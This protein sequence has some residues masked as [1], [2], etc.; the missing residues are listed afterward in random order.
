MGGPSAAIVLD[1]LIDLGLR[2]AVRIGTCAGLASG[3]ELGALLVAEGAL[4]GDGASRALGAGGRV[5]GDPGL[6][7]GLRLA[8]AGAGAGLVASTDL[9][10]GAGGRT[11]WVGGD[12]G[13]SWRSA[14]AMAVDLETATMF[15]LAAVRGVAV[16]CVLVVTD[17]LVPD[18]RI[19][20]DALAGAAERAGRLGLA[21]LGPG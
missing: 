20:D 15:T 13:A 19:A 14:G 10:R 11:R 3:L 21:G 2:R 9:F 5:D 18:R 17:L 8:G 7:A 4:A 16:G 1:E 12:A 6:T